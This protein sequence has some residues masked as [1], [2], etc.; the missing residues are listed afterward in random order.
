MASSTVTVRVGNRDL[1]LG[2]T[3]VEMR[4]ST[5]EYTAGQDDVLRARL[6]SD[7]FLF[8]RG[9]IPEATL[10][11]GYKDF[12]VARTL[13]ADKK[14]PLVFY[15]ANSSC[16]ACHQ[17]AKAAIELG[18]KNVFIMPDGIGGWETAKL[19]TEKNS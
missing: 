19:A 8:I 17:G 1:T 15:C 18:Y 12:D 7:G 11:S 6:E 5:A 3:L 16:G 10:L 2:S 9:V 4:D 13:P 14:S